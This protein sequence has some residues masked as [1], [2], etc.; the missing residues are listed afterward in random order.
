[1]NN[2]YFFNIICVRYVAFQAVFENTV[3][4][5]FFIFIQEAKLSLG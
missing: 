1:M 5:S 3:L 2:V 4:R